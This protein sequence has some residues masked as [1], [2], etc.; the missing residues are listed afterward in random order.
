MTIRSAADQKPDLSHTKTVTANLKHKTAICC[1]QTQRSGTWAR[2]RLLC[3]EPAVWTCSPGCLHQSSSH[4]T[5]FPGGGL[6]IAGLPRSIRLHMQAAFSFWR[7]ELFKNTV[8]LS[9]VWNPLTNVQIRLVFHIVAFHCH[10]LGF[11]ENLHT[12]KDSGHRFI[13]HHTFHF[14]C[15]KCL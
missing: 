9:A 7:P 12:I 14:I 11:Q 3:A 8:M 6:I 2:S 5:L 1:S 4:Y 15:T 10:L 13:I